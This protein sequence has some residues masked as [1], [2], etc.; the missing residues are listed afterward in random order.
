VN[1]IERLPDASTKFVPPGIFAKWQPEYAEHGI[2]T[3]PVRIGEVKKPA[4]KNYLKIGKVASAAFAKRFGESA[5]FGFA[6]KPNRIT[7]LDVDSADESILADALD[8]HGQTPI[9]VRS[10][11]GHFHAW[12]KRN[13]EGRHI[14]PWDGLPIDVLGGGYVV[15]PPSHAAKGTYEFLQGSLDDL[16]SLPTLRNVN[17]LIKV[18]K[19]PLVGPE[20]PL[21]DWTEM[22]EGDGRNNTLFRELGHKAHHVAGFEDLLLY[23]R[24]RNA[25][26]GEPMP[27]TEVVR[28][29][30]N[31]WGYECAGTNWCGAGRDRQKEVDSFMSD[32]D[33]FFLLSYLRSHQGADATFM[34]ANGLAAKFGWDRKRF[35]RSRRRLVDA[36][37][38]VQV[39]WPTQGRPAL[40]R[41]PNRLG[42]ED[43]T[44]R[45]LVKYRWSDSPT[46]SGQGG[47]A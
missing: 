35:A 28:I 4:V 12:F 42:A 15:A 19:H 5:A 45:G 13:G 7:V 40:F 16:T 24:T 33:G 47:Q 9:I 32:P 8:K 17:N 27:D 43:T 26:F 22:A 34:V 6:C 10:G 21:T 30:G 18:P 38:V 46:L 1:I 37:Y 23:A 20:V 3:F 14:R 41:W 2:A 44:T 29:A 31:I 11:S 25:E 39:R 36:G